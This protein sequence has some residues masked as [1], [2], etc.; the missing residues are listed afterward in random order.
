[1]A[2]KEELPKDWAESATKTYNMIVGT[3]S[4]V[5]EWFNGRWGDDPSEVLSLYED[6]RSIYADDVHFDGDDEERTELVR[7]VK[8]VV[9]L[10]EAGK[11]LPPPANAFAVFQNDCLDNLVEVTVDGEA[12]HLNEWRALRTWMEE[13]GTMPEV[14]QALWNTRRISFDEAL[15]RI[16][17]ARPRPIGH[18]SLVK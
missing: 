5:V 9:A 2:K 16:A 10:S 17:D 1:M 3:D 14:G 12:F 7:W 8:E 15:A 6:L 18:G 11:S 13:G 4:T